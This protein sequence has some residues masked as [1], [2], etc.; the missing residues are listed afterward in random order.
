MKKWRRHTG[1]RACSELAGAPR[2]QACAALACSTARPCH[3]HTHAAAGLDFDIGI[4]GKYGLF[5]SVALGVL[6]QYDWR[7][8]ALARLVKAWARRRGL[9]DSAGGTFNSFALTLM[10][11]CE[12][13]EEGRNRVE[14]M[15]A[16]MDGRAGA[17]AH[18]FDGNAVLWARGGLMCGGRNRWHLPRAPAG[19]R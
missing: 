4:G 16:G 9:N 13:W 11:R 19:Q 5:K 1:E 2:Q 12:G 15:V 18:V 7:Y 14:T 17:L 3:L 8:G 6:S 10:V